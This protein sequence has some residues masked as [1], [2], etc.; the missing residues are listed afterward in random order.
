MINYRVTVQKSVDDDP[1]IVSDF[2]D[3]E[4]ADQLVTDLYNKGEYDIISITKTEIKNL[5]K[6]NY[7]YVQKATFVSEYNVK[8]FYSGKAL[9]ALYGNGIL[10]FDIQQFK[11]INEQQF[12]NKEK[13]K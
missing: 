7:P 10:G 9:N 4:S 8:T 2:N 1:I 13:E 6:Y 11:K 12:K 5:T 3:E